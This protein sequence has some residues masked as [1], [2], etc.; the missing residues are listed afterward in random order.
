[1]T[2]PEKAPRV[3]SAQDQMNS[4]NHFDF[5]VSSDEDEI[6]ERL[7]NAGKDINIQDDQTAGLI[8]GRLT[9]ERL[10]DSG[11]RKLWAT[12]L[13]SAAFNSSLYMFRKVAKFDPRTLRRFT[14]PRYFTE[15]GSPI[16]ARDAERTTIRGLVELEALS[17]SV[18]DQRVAAGHPYKW[19]RET[20]RSLARGMSTSAMRLASYGFDVAGLDEAEVRVQV[21]E[22]AI[23]LHEE[24]M[25]TTKRTTFNPSLAQLR[26]MDTPLGQDILRHQPARIVKVF[27]ETS[28]EIGK[29]S[30]Y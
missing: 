17:Q 16:D 11:D 18:T 10:D 25:S 1:M 24:V 7:Q 22:S 6:A 29:N 23:K 4:A 21:E 14:L 8:V 13:G 19:P 9:L 12:V 30:G 28:R 26:T 2:K 3:Y 15:S 5:N 27:K 20:T